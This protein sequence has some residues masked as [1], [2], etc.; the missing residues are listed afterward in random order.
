MPAQPRHQQRLRARR[1]RAHDD[2]C[3]HALLDQHARDVEGVVAATHHR[4]MRSQICARL[5]D[6]GRAEMHAARHRQPARILD[7]VEPFIAAKS[8]SGRDHDG[9]AGQ[10]LRRALVR[11]RNVER[12]AAAVRA[13]EALRPAA[14]PRLDRGLPDVAREF[15]G[16]LPRGLARPP[17][18]PVVGIGAR[19]RHAAQRSLL[20]DDARAQSVVREPQR[21]GHAGG[22]AAD[23]RHDRRLRHRQSLSCGMSGPWFARPHGSPEWGLPQA[24]RPPSTREP[25]GQHAIRARSQGIDPHHP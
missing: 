2:G 4:D 9:R 7:L 24:F 25:H 23:N 14:V 5:A 1:L 19:P 6:I 21:A 18:Q 16:V 12:K 15:V 17:E 20:L 13:Q 8:R 10:R 11:E 3:L 22:P